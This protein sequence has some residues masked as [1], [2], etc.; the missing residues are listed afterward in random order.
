MLSSFGSDFRRSQDPHSEYHKL[1][2]LPHLASLAL[3]SSPGSSAFLSAAA[4]LG[5]TAPAGRA[6]PSPL[7]KAWQQPATSLFP[8]VGD[9]LHL[10]SAL[11]D[12]MCLSIMAE[13][14]GGIHSNVFG[15]AHFGAGF[16]APQI[17]GR[18]ATE[19]PL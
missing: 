5:E 16:A 6:S 11:I 2:R 14:S 10:V 19:P 18:P 7:L 12:Y 17:P 3:A 13:S 1:G 9:V 8:I 4:G 15:H